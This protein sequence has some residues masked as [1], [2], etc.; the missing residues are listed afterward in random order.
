MDM[1]SLDSH[2]RLESFDEEHN[3]LDS[4]DNGN[5]IENLEALSEMNLTPRDDEDDDDEV[6]VMNRGDE[7]FRYDSEYCSMGL[8]PAGSEI[9]SKEVDGRVRERENSGS[10]DGLNESFDAEAPLKLEEGSW[11]PKSLQKT[12]TLR[13]RLTIDVTNGSGNAGPWDEDENDLLDSPVSSPTQPIYNNS[14]KMIQRTLSPPRSRHQIGSTWSVTINSLRMSRSSFECIEHLRSI[15]CLL[16]DIDCYDRIKFCKCDFLRAVEDLRKSPYVKF[17]GN[18]ELFR[19][20]TYIVITF[21]DENIFNRLP[22]HMICEVFLF[23]GVKE[24]M[25]M[26]MVC[27]EWRSLS[28]SDM[29]WKDLYFHRYL[30]GNPGS[31]PQ[32]PRTNYKVHYA[33]RLKDPELGDKVEVAWRG[34]FRLEGMDVYQGM[35]WWCA[36]VVDRHSAHGKYKIRYPGWESRWDE[37]VPRDRLRWAVERNVLCHI[38]TGSVVELWCC[39]ANVPGA[40]LESKVK[41][42]RGNRF[43]IN[44]VLTVGA[45]FQ[46]KPLW[47]DR[48]R[49]RLVRYPA[50][51]EEKRLSLTGSRGRSTS[52]S[53]FIFG[54]PSRRHSSADMSTTGASG[55]GGSQMVYGNE[56]ANGGDEDNDHGSRGR[57]PSFG[58]LLGRIIFGPDDQ[59]EVV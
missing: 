14:L 9:N 54:S 4:F 1:T 7:S 40:W 22:L 5:D 37:W 35:A 15:C 20:V 57:R 59:D 58:A 18:D 2:D 17:N 33:S 52:F 38:T 36:E 28:G 23:L 24:H 3:R 34:K 43:C 51:E 31:I 45:T 8:G 19:E 25:T 6:K 55:G 26:P 16:E 56:A 21:F 11:S 44:R 49:L 47:V 27:H 53:E 13:K 30:R 42:V 46:S 29:I 50:D 12:P 39:G 10:I 41:K 48:D 32:A